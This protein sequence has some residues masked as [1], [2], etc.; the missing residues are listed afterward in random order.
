MASVAP[1]SLFL[2]PDATS[3]TI[4]SSRSVNPF[5]CRVEI[6]SPSPMC[7]SSSASAPLMRGSI[8]TSPRQTVR[9]ACMRVW[10]AE[11]FRMTPLAPSRNARTCSSFSSHAVRTRTCVFGLIL[12]TAGTASSPL[13]CGIRMSS[14]STSG[15]VCQTSSTMS[16]ALSAS[17]TTSMSSSVSRMVRNPSR[18]NVWS[19]MITSRRFRGNTVICIPPPA[20]L[21]SRACCHGNQERHLGPQA[22]LAPDPQRPS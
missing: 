5:S 15:R 16:S 22:G 1:T 12:R 18:N 19:S 9:M 17:A 3:R 10:R 8:Q 13:P 14:R 6:G 21:R 20:N 4:S 11:S 7:D 2:Y